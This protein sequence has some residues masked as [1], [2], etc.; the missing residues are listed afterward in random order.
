MVLR[1]LEERDIPGMLEWM[2]D[3]E[4]SGFFVFD[5]SGQTEES[6][7]SFIQSSMTDTYRHFAVVDGGD[8]Y[9]G[10]IS[11]KHIDT[12]NQ[13]AEYAVALRR[14][15]IGTGLAAAAT[16]AL[17]ETAFY[18]LGLNRVYLNVLSDNIR[19]R[20]FYE[21]MGF[22]PEGESV[23]HLRIDGKFRSLTWYA[24]LKREFEE[25]R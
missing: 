14:Q 22:R 5:A 15:A 12:A 13:T 23:E 11:L 20:K 8:D 10:T 25:K 1:A 7:R 24:I 16:R 18:E 9:M 2:H 4:L 19:A 6:A 3:P 17:L 21:K